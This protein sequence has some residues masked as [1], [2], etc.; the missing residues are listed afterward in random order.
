MRFRVTVH[1]TARLVDRHAEH[2]G[3]LLY[4]AWSKF[5]YGF[6]G[7]LTAAPLDG[8][9]YCAEFPVRIVYEVEAEHAGEAVADVIRYGLPGSVEVARTEVEAVDDELLLPFLVA[10]E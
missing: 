4:D 3:H 8:G 5:R 2:P 1:G 7:P 6:V 9:G 10:A